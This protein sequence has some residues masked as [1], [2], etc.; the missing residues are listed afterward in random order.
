MRLERWRDGV[1]EGR[2]RLRRVVARLHVK[3]RP[4]RSSVPSRRGGVPVFSRPS[5]SPS[6]PSVAARPA[7]RRLARPARRDGRVTDMDEATQE[8]PRG[9][10]HRTA[11]ESIARRES[12]RRRPGPLRSTRSS[13]SASMISSPPVLQHGVLH[14]RRRR[15]CGPPARAGPRT[16]GPL[17]RL[18]RRNWMPAAIG[19]A[20]HQPIERIDLAHQMSL[21]EPAD[22]RVARHRADGLEAMRDERRPRAEPRRGGGSFAPGVPAADDDRRQSSSSSMK[23]RVGRRLQ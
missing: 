13:T 17:R 21:A 4:S 11:S 2:E 10:H 22:R 16:A 3:A 6:R 8:G 14:R 23:S 12:R 7:A 9:Q 20:A 19:D 1:G 18:S 15:A 5:G